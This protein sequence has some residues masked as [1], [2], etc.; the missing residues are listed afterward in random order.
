MAN[1]QFSV[2]IP[3]SP[4]MAKFLAKRYGNPVPINNKN[5]LGTTL[6]SLMEKPGFH[7]QMKPNDKQLYFYKQFTTKLQSVAPL[8]LMKDYNYNLTIDQVIQMNRFFDNYFEQILYIFCAAKINRNQRH[9]GYDD[10]IFEFADIHEIAIGQDV[11]FDCLKKNEYR[12]RKNLEKKLFGE[13]SPQNKRNNP[14][15]FV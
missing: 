4:Y 14:L 13:L 12:Y 8:S 3:T 6:I 1:K 11:S 15:L 10:A 7:V 9:V 5:L 2:Q